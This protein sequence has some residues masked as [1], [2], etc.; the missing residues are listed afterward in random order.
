MASIIEE[1]TI[2]APPAQVLDGAGGSSRFMWITDVLP[3]E[4]GEPVRQMMSQGIAVIKAT[5]EGAPSHLATP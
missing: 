3:D 1:P 2:E 5:L 4:L